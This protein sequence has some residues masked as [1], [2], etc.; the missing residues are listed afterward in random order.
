VL[1]GFYLLLVVVHPAGMGWGDV[2]LAGLVGGVL[3]VPLWQAVLVGVFAA[4]LLGA[5]VGVCDGGRARWAEGGPPVRTFMIAGVLLAVS[6][7][8]WWAGTA[9]CSAERWPTT[10]WRLG[11]QA[12]NRAGGKHLLEIA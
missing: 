3:A 6:R 10:P 1:L 12:F 5:T 2:K 8:R 4:F 7:S 9:T 11:N